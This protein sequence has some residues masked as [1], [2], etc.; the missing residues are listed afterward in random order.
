MANNRVRVGING[1]GVIGKRVADAVSL[2]DDMELVGVA[3]V[4]HDY[5]IRV[6]LEP[7]YRVHN[8]AIVI[9]ENIDA[10][11]ALTAIEEDGQRSIAKT[12]TSLG[13]TKNFLP[14]SEPVSIPHLAGPDVPHPAAVAVRAAHVACLCEGFK[15]AEEPVEWEE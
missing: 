10:I 6:A 12:D 3:D 8:E 11:R 2:Q 4:V 15:G 1:Y 13:I 7:G 9:P 5:R 14:S